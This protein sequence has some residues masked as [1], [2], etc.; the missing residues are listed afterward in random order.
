MILN[1]TTFLVV[2]TLKIFKY[3]VQ[4]CRFFILCNSG[5]GIKIELNVKCSFWSMLQDNSTNA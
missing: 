2:F 1:K 5:Q 4:W 3:S